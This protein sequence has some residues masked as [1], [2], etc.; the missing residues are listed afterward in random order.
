MKLSKKKKAGIFGAI[1]GVGILILSIFKPELVPVAQQ[2]VEIIDTNL[3]NEDK[4][5]CVCPERSIENA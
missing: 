2:G 5:E 1:T 4:T 3:I